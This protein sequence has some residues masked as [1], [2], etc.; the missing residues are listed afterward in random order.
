MEQGSFDHSGEESR[1]LPPEEKEPGDGGSSAM[2]KKPPE[3]GFISAD[4][5]EREGHG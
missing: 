4:T 5:K 1:F 3:T 2:S